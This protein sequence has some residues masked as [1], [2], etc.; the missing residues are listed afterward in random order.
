MAHN[1]R[2][3]KASRLR[4]GLHRNYFGPDV[5]D[6][7][8]AA[9]TKQEPRELFPL[10]DAVDLTAGALPTLHQLAWRNIDGPLYGGFSF[11]ALRSHAVHE[12]TSRTLDVWHPREFGGNL[13]K[14]SNRKAVDARC[15]RASGLSRNYAA[16]FEGHSRMNSEEKFELGRTV[17]TANA[18]RTLHIDDIMKAM[19][20]HHSGDWGDVCKNDYDENQIALVHGYRLFSVYHSREGVKFWIITE[21][22]RSSTTV[23][24]PDDY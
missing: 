8:I 5:A 18:I 17:A 4:T 19:Q 3:S 11:G 23:L 24:M 20:R 21:A 15:G 12:V 9:T 10:G 13:K 1:D 22:D 14:N 2:G 6:H 7:S 16:D